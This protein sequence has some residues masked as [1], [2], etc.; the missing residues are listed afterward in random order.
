MVG[1][2]RQYENMTPDKLNQLL[3]Q[4][5]TIGQRPLPS[6]VNVRMIYIIRNTGE[7]HQCRE[8]STGVFEWVSVIPV[9][10][11]SNISGLRTLGSG[12][13]QGA[14]GGHAHPSVI[15]DSGFSNIREVDWN[16]AYDFRWDR[17]SE[18]VILNKTITIDDT[19]TVIV[20]ALITD[21]L[22]SAPVFSLSRGTITL[23]ASILVETLNS[24]GFATYNATSYTL[25][26]VDSGVAPGT[27]TYSIHLSSSDIHSLGGYM[28]IHAIT[29][30]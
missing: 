7:W 5:G 16:I 22:P 25:Y 14:H 9:D 18:G 2:V 23:P 6:I 10:P 24:F 26:Y 15:D 19:S 12:A 11:S 3:V 21:Y 27:Y 30:K 29:Y 20:S 1:F 4:W 17:K 8:T 13:N 28:D